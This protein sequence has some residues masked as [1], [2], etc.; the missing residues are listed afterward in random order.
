MKKHLWLAVVACMLIVCMFSV[1]ASASGSSNTVYLNKDYSGAD[2]DGTSDK[3]FTTIDAA[4]AALDTNADGTP[5][6]GTIILKSDYTIAAKAATADVFPIT[7]AETHITGLTGSETL[8]FTS[9]SNKKAV[10]CPSAL[11]FS[12]LVI[13]YSYSSV[14]SLDF[15]AQS[16]LTFGENLTFKVKGYPLAD[17][18]DGNSNAR[19][20]DII[21]VLMGDS[22]VET[23]K[24]VFNM[25]S[26]TISAVYGGSKSALLVEGEI[27]I[28]GT[29]KI[30]K[31]LQCGSTASDVTTS[32]VNVSGNADVSTLYLGGHGD[33]KSVGSSIVNISG[34]TV[35]IIDT[36]RTTGYKINNISLTISGT[37][38][39][40]SFGSSSCNFVSGKTRTLTISKDMTIPTG[41]G[42][43]W[44]NI[45]VP[46]DADVNVTGEYTSASAAHKVD[47]TLKL[48]NET[49]A[50][51]LSSANTGSGTI[52]SGTLPPSGGEGGGSVTPPPTPTPTLLDTVYVGGANASSTN[53]GSAADKAVSTLAEAYA[54]LKST[55]GTIVLCGDVSAVATTGSSAPFPAKDGKVTIQGNTGSEVLSITPSASANTGKAISTEILSALEWKNLTFNWANP[56][57][58]ALYIFSGPDFTIGE[59][60]TIL[61]N[62]AAFDSAKDRVA[63]RVS[64]YSNDSCTAPKFTQKSGILSAVYCGSD[65]VDISSY[66]VSILGDSKILIM[67]QGGATNNTV[68]AGEITIGGNADIAALY[69]GGYDSKSIV[70]KVES[71]DVT[72]T[73]GN[74]DKVIGARTENVEVGNVSFTVS[75]NSTI[76]AFAIGN[77]PSKT[78]T[79]YVLTIKDAIVL[80]GLDSYWT[81]IVMED[82]AKVYLA[83]AYTL[84]DNIL[85]V[86][87]GA[88]MYLS[89]ANN[90][91]APTNYV[92]S[93]SAQTGKVVLDAHNHTLT[94]VDAACSSTGADGN[95]EY[96]VCQ[97][98]NCSG[99]GN[100]YLDEAGKKPVTVAGTKTT[101]GHDL[102][103]NAEKVATDCFHPGNVE[104]WHC[105]NC[106]KNYADSAATTEITTNVV[107]NTTHDLEH[108]D[109]EP[110]THTEDGIL[111]HWHCKLCDWRW[112][113][114]DLA[115]RLYSEIDPK[116]GHGED[117]KQVDAKDASCT[118]D[119]C[120]EHQYCE[121][122]DKYYTPNVYGDVFPS[123]L[124]L[125]KAEVFIE[126]RH[127]LKHATA[128]AADTCLDEG[129]IEYWYCDTEGCANC[130]KFFSDAEGETEISEADTV[131]IGAHDLKKVDEVPAEA[132][133]A[134]TKAHWFCK[135][136]EKFF[137]DAEGKTE[138]KAS[139]L[140]IPALGYEVEKE[141]ETGVSI[142]GLENAAHGESY[143]FTV[144]LEEGYVKGK[145]FKVMVNGKELKANADGSY[146][147]LSVTGKLEITVTGA[148]KADSIIPDTGDHAL[149]LPMILLL[150]LSAAGLTVLGVDTKRRRV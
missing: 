84:G 22:A 149:I 80:K 21:V 45:V 137:S 101:G 90:T 87:D 74:I 96:W 52:Y 132:D 13:N 41:F 123:K 124:E 128:V 63:I 81:S 3:P 6:G 147:I 57:D 119:G 131:I 14:S 134:G 110:A 39:V 43:Y 109:A 25:E 23:N 143:T 86:A 59:G 30:V 138:V 60:V 55:G 8:I 113:D 98:A 75:G 18:S 112:S 53:D 136:C 133:K 76:G 85:S 44:T 117:L 89:S 42:S 61:K 102:T 108:I 146:T 104:H 17:W 64:A 99:N 48:N 54:L 7:S 36:A 10:T 50:A 122:C 148:V 92:K 26:G 49:V 9:T 68:G 150:A 145:D 70:R 144:K 107:V 19:T 127:E 69:L 51:T 71:I 135:R 58:G 72:M 20:K 73:G 121:D 31:M 93:G 114:E 120:I 111:E 139:D 37:A 65:Q 34:G 125:T 100:C 126:C 130:G 11:K 94:H 46:A 97:D 116:T 35:G 103:H 66:N 47:G 2:S 82:D 32:K 79:S 27:N 28:G 83:D 78:G 106:G 88:V 118:E 67:L 4:F 77:H 142:E 91:T 1:F 140:V 12:N 141:T 38:V 16:S 105:E 40:N 115:H 56:D 95:I 5:D 29:A 62:G 33:N 24:A 15:Y 129:N